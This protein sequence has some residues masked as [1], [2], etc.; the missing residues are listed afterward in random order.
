MRG[1]A[2]LFVVACAAAVTA[3]AQPIGA[4]S[5]EIVEVPVWLSMAPRLDAPALT[6]E[7]FELRVNGK[8]Q[9]INF[10]EVWDES[11]AG[12]MCVL[13]FYRDD[14]EA[15]KLEV[16]VDDEEVRT[17]RS[18]GRLGPA[19]HDHYDGLL[20]GVTSREGVETG[21]VPLQIQVSPYA[22]G[23]YLSI[24]FPR[25]GPSPDVPAARDRGEGLYVCIINEWGE[26]MAF[27]QR[28]LLFDPLYSGRSGFR[29]WYTLP[30]GRYI[31]RAF[32]TLHDTVIGFTR[33][34]FTVL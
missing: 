2:A 11:V 20:L 4:H 26:R 1:L 3:A 13:G 21:G 23:A 6:R 29:Q 22:Q 30:Q 19:L 32:V 14:D 24:G 15:G 18:R 5:G 33:T 16:K 28:Q 10:F 12:V 31:A 34:E 8:P 9:P 27:T 25:E 17:L 7:A